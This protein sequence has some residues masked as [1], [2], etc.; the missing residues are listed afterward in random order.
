VRCARYETFPT[1]LLGALVDVSRASRS[2]YLSDLICPFLRNAGCQQCTSTPNGLL[3]IGRVF[4]GYADPVERANES[5]TGPNKR[6]CHHRCQP[7]DGGDDSQTG[8][9]QGGQAQQQTRHTA[10]S[11]AFA[12]LGFGVR[13]VR[14]FL[15]RTIQVTE[16][17][18]RVIRYQADVVVRNACL[19]QIVRCRFRVRVR[20]E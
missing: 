7:S 6:S 16:L 11:R 3:I 17:S 4:M 5:D 19:F 1:I 14:R 20:I 12:S 15:R 18:A 8:N 9:C 13:T 10:H 2:Q